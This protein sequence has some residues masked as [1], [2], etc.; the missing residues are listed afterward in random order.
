MEG[1]AVTMAFEIIHDPQEKGYEVLGDKDTTAPEHE[2]EQNYIAKSLG[3]KINN[4]IQK[5]LQTAVQAVAPIVKKVA[6]YIGAAAKG[7]EMVFGGS[8]SGD[9]PALPSAIMKASGAQPAKPLR[10]L[11]E[12]VPQMS[13]EARF[14]PV[15]GTG[16]EL[17]SSA[18][19]KMYPGFD[20]A[21]SIPD[22][23]IAYLV[24][25]AMSPAGAKEG[26]GATLATTEGKVIPAIEKQLNRVIDD[27]LA[28][29][30]RPSYGRNAYTKSEGRKGIMSIFKNKDNLKITNQFQEETGKLPETLNEL[31]QAQ[32]QT[33]RGL[34]EKF[35][36]MSKNASQ[37]GAAVNYERVADNIGKDIMSNKTLN[38]FYPEVVAYANK[39]IEQLKAAGSATTTEAQDYIKEL[40]ASLDAFYAN[41][42][43]ENAQKAAVDA[44]VARKLRDEQN[45]V[46]EMA[47]KVPG[48]PFANSPAY[49]E[50]RDE[51][52]SLKA[53]RKDIQRATAVDSRKAPK[54]LIDFSDIAVGADL[55]RAIAQFDPVA[56]TSGA[57]MKLIAM[58]YR[59]INNP[60]TH[61]KKMFQTLEGTAKAM[62][63]IGRATGVETAQQ[64]VRSVGND[65]QPP[66]MGKPTPAPQATPTAQ[67]TPQPQAKGPQGGWMTQLP[68]PRQ[69]KGRKIQD[70]NGAILV[71]DGTRWIPANGGA[72]NAV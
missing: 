63:L 16:V 49:K 55:A 37:Y 26:L 13:P 45:S 59:Y 22:K 68:D 20:V 21:K 53:M 72:P 40:N 8:G 44:L 41:K 2:P 27:G 64:G 3:S 34:F 18:L 56:A 48:S 65:L 71:S 4:V 15:I 50:L 28:H 47:N 17:A 51:Y 38:N 60:N 70:H 1:G 54:G 57:A 32:E 5:P 23:T 14:G 7:T 52:G 31:K 24:A 11:P 58:R 19:N 46:I 25:G 29:G 62:P 39:K 67:P 33:E 36:A 61:I 69:Y 35:D 6:P 30:L 10:D 66:M 43:Y 42:T 12:N 9:Y